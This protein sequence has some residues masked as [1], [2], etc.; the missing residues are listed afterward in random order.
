MKKTV[1]LILIFAFIFLINGQKVQ[2]QQTCCPTGYKP[3]A[4]CPGKPSYDV[5]KMDILEA[6]GKN[7]VR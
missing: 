7:A 6:V 1:L 4:E 5:F 2:A 3:G